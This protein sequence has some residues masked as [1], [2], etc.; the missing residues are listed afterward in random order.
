VTSV[1]HRI[2]REARAPRNAEIAAAI[3]ALPTRVTIHPVRDPN[4]RCAARGL[5]QEPTRRTGP[6]A[7]RRVPV[8][9]AAVLLALAAAFAAGGCADSDDG[10]A[11]VPADTRS[12]V[13]PADAADSGGGSVEEFPDDGG[14][15]V[16]IDE[17]ISE[18]SLR[19]IRFE[20]TDPQGWHYQGTLPW[21]RQSVQFSKDISSSPPGTARLVASLQ[22]DEVSDTTFQVDNP[23]RPGG[24][25]IS[26]GPGYFAY[27]VPDSDGLEFVDFPSVVGSCTLED[28]Y[29]YQFHPF[30]FQYLCPAGSAEWIADE[31]GTEAWIDR[32]ISETSGAQPVYVMH[33]GGVGPICY[34]FISATGAV[35]LG[36]YADG[37]C[38]GRTLDIEVVGGEPATDRG[39][40]CPQVQAF[41]AVGSGNRDKADNDVIDEVTE[42]FGAGLLEPERAAGAGEDLIRVERIDYP[43]VSVRSPT[44]V[45][46]GLRF[47][48]AYHRS[49]V[50]GKDAL[51]ARLTEFM[52]A[53]VDAKVILSGFSQGAQVVGDVYQELEEAGGAA[54]EQVFGVVLFG[55][56][57]FNPH[58][59]GRGSSK[60]DLQHRPSR[61]GSLGTRPEYGELRSRVRSYC[62]RGDPVCQ[63]AIIVNPLKPLQDHTNY[64][65]TGEASDAARWLS[66]ELRKVIAP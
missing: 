13:D 42:L 52:S 36:E 19:E 12:Y 58:P 61:G 37:D 57:Y 53:C 47:G 60:G 2:Q 39:R 49:V 18:S 64:A 63:G 38:Q 59:R 48:G 44:G 17:P 28:N 24:P 41:Y 23:G 54:Y 7:V 21:P 9:A 4:G 35:D 25:E 1:W 27:P 31:D 30:E 66:T 50:D 3:R 10:L 26:I 40:Q 33:F 55:D 20:L 5:R 6:Q 51:R 16:A 8:R 45:G 32:V 46:A 34:V 43:A 14:D 56:P 15:V 62:H 29:T 11:D 22:G 65:D